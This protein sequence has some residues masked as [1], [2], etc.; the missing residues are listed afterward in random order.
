[1]S[2]DHGRFAA[3]A[4]S[5][6]M[7]KSNGAEGGTRTPTGCPTTPSRWR[8]CQFHHFGTG[9]VKGCRT[10]LRGRPTAPDA[11]FRRRLRSLRRL[12][13]LSRLWRALDRRRSLSRSTLD[14]ICRRLR[15][16]LLLL[17]CLDLRLPLSNLF[18]GW[19]LNRGLRYRSFTDRFRP[20]RGGVQDRL[21]F[22]FSGDG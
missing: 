1:M 11:L 9:D 21:A 2:E 7:D 14:D 18:R 20:S 16:L 17:L 12:L 6:R 15:R 3:S 13:R 19:C 22:N 4:G 8:V 5:D 10:G